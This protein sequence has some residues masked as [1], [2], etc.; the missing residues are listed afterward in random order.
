MNEYTGFGDV[1]KG[2]WV[3]GENDDVDGIVEDKGEN[4]E[5]GDGEENDKDTGKNVK[6]V[7]VKRILVIVWKKK[8]EMVMS[9]SL[10]YERVLKK[11]EEMVWNFS[12]FYEKVLLQLW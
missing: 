2:E 10:F 6:L 9:H 1:N 8:R 4:D 5:D 3:A 7:I 12:L 11:K